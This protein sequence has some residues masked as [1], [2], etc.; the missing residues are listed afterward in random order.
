MF[1][2]WLNGKNLR[3]F[4][5]LQRAKSFALDYKKNHHLIKEIEDFVITNPCDNTFEEIDIFELKG[6]Y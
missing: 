1:Y 2:I 3:R 5:S 6:I 4:K